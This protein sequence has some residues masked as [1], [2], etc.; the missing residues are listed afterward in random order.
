MSVIV[1]VVMVSEFKA[2]HSHI[3][4]P[5]LSRVKLKAVPRFIN[6]ISISSNRY[7]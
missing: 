2:G 7:R 1:V 4:S 3:P 5:S 6:L